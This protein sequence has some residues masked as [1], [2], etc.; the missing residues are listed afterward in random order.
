MAGYSGTPLAKKL[1]I[2]SGQRIAF[3]NPPASFAQDLGEVPDDLRDV[4]GARSEIDLA[5][6]FVTEQRAL[7]R[8]FA[9]LAKRLAPA[10]MLWV[11]WPKKA[12]K[13]PTDVTENIVRDHG[14][15]VG[16]VDVKI[17]AVNEIW[18]GR[19]FVRRLKD[20]PLA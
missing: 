9:P 19:K 4:S 15:Q 6:L 13:M 2:K 20:R 8:G 11:S 12:S 7:K 17:C 5:V 14:L 10:G 1:G 16:L 3:I 18:S